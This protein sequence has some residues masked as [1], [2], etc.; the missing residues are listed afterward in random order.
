MTAPLITRWDGE[1]FWPLKRF[2]AQCDKDFVVGE[3]YRVEIVEDRSD[4]SH[5]HYFA[6][7]TEAWRNLPDDLAGE[8][9][10]FEHFRKRGLIATGHY[11]ERRFVASSP[12]EARK[13][14]AFLRPLDEFAVFSI[15][16]PVVIERKAKSQSRKAMGG[17]TFQKSKTDVL[18]W[19]ASLIG[20]TPSDIPEHEAA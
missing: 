13:L 17:P 5:N 3:F 15:A 2:A 1:A 18:D 20:I 4:R 16:G 8:Y 19:A 7:L 12:I 14:L 10:S 6:A 11:A 9:P